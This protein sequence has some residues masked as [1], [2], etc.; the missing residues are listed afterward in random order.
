MTPLRLAI[1]T[2]HALNRA[3]R[4]A[5]LNTRRSVGADLHQQADPDPDPK[6]RRRIGPIDVP[7]RFR[8]A[9]TT[10]TDARQ[11]ER[12]A[13]WLR[14]RGIASATW[15]PNRSG[16][17]KLWVSPADVPKAADLLARE[18]GAP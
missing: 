5:W 12:L 13:A 2:G 11:G 6:P 1:P 17:G 16:T 9:E 3:Q 8:R 14:A 15:A 7:D 18:G 10:V 4:Q